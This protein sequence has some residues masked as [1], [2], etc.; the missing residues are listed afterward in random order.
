MKHLYLEIMY[1]LLENYLNNGKARFERKYNNNKLP[2][3]IKVT[4]EECYHKNL[5][6][7]FEDF[8]EFFE[9]EKPCLLDRLVIYMKNNYKDED[10]YSRFIR[11]YLNKNLPKEY[12]NIVK[13]VC[14][15]N[16]PQLLDDYTDFLAFG[17]F[18]SALYFYNYHDA[19]LPE[20]FQD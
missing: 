7:L 3:I 19:E 9:N 8:E 17:T 10:G 20:E 16:G 2:K 14:E 12:R 15:E 4:F 18:P 6:L 1:H 11:D 5:E 13:Y